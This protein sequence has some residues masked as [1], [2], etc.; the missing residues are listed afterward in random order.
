MKKLIAAMAASLFI[1]SMPLLAHHA[2]EGIIDDDVYDMIDS[3]L[4]DTPHADM[5]TSDLGSTTTI[6][7]DTQTVTQLENM[8]DDGLLDYASLLDGEI[9]LNISFNPDGTTTTTI[10]QTQ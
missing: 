9:S 8:I 3:L 5:T 6:T 1:T 4:A 10:T 2:A 7:I